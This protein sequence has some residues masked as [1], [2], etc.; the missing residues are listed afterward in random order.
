MLAYLE[1]LDLDALGASHRARN[2]LVKPIQKLFELE[3]IK[4]E[5]TQDAIEFIAEKALDFKLGARICA[6]SAKLS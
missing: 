6:A 2:A 5:F 4:L 3:G 1:P